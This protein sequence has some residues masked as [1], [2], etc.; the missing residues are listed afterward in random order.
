MTTSPEL[1]DVIFFGS[2]EFGVPVLR[3]LAA[4]GRV[5]MVVS[6]PDRE[7]GRGK[8][9]TPTPVSACAAELGL[10]L[11]RPADCNEPAALAELRAAA[12][13]AGER[14]RAQ[15]R[16]QPAPCFV[17]I[18]YGQKLSNALLEGIFAVNLHGSVLPRW[19]GAAPIQRALME[20]DAQ[21]GVTVI[22]LAQRMDAGLVYAVRT[23]PVG[24]RQTAGELHDAL[25]ALGPE[26]VESV[27]AAWM[28]GTLRGAAQDE[29]QATRARKLGRADAWVDL[30]MD[31]ARVRARINGLNPWPGC[32]AQVEGRPLL[33]RRCEEVAGAGAGGAMGAPEAGTLDPD[34]T[35]WCGR[36]AVRLLEVQAPGGRAMEFTAWAR[37]IRLQSRAT[38]RSAPVQE[39]PR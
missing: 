7:A 10:E 3:A 28:A 15:G 1:P 18:A 16:A 9:P 34:G 13:R 19:R 27:L 2:G 11:R 30:S 32:A 31:G 38:L 37:G 36:G 5:A 26:A 23:L 20:G 8:V 25:S 33:L 39:A 14:A 21:A 24:P 4:K 35:L 22:S 6:Q 29:S 17:V 12:A